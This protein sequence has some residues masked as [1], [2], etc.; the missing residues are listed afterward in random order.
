M[1]HVYKASGIIETAKSIEGPYRN[2]METL[3]NGELDSA[4][5]TTKLFCNVV[6]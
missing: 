4:E 1:F 2:R 5:A 6:L 3:L